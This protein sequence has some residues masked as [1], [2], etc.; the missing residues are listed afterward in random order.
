MTGTPKPFNLIRW[1]AVLS[2]ITIVIGAVSMAT[3][4]SHFLAEEVLRRD[5]MLT[6]QFIVSVAENESS[7]FGLPRPSSVAEL[8]AGTVGADLLG[9][10]DQVVTKAKNEFFGHI[11]ILPDVLLANV[12]ARD[13]TIVWSHNPSAI[14][15]RPGPHDELEQAFQSRILVAHGFIGRHRHTQSQFLLGQPDHYYV[16]NYVPLY[17]SYGNA[18]SVVEIYKEPSGLFATIRRGQVL[19]WVGS[20][21]TGLLIYLAL[22]WL[23]RRGSVL[24]NNQQ[25]QLVDSEMLVMMGEMA[26]A[27]AHGI[28]N[29]LAA[30]RSSAELA[31]EG[32][33]QLA[34]KGAN[35]II[36][37]VDRL[38]YWVRDLLVFS[39]PPDGV[40]EQVDMAAIIRDTLRNFAPR[41]ER[42]GITPQWSEPATEL[43]KVIGNQ[44]L[45]VQAFNSIIANAVEAMPKGGSLSISTELDTARRRLRVSVSDSGV[46]MTEK[47]LSMVFKPFHTTKTRGLGVGLALVKRIIERYGGSIF[48]ESKENQGTRVHMIFNPAG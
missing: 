41:F 22:F 6:S 44:A 35:D 7:H 40:A 25:Q 42:A 1:F 2:L 8:V 21:L 38:S 17:D 14:G 31:L 3:I 10:D 5:A 29:P 46:G 27:V 33:E 18:V 37:Q 4:L 9:I 15:S 24:I 47:Q 16:E 28:R 39:R 48:L 23:V 34:R 19:V 12:Y 45:F 43:P 26:Q 36:Q 32:D 11:R 20:L 13:R 30:I